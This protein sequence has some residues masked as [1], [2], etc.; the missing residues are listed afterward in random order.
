MKK[1]QSLVV[2]G[3]QLDKIETKV[4]KLL[5]KEISIKPHD[6]KPLVTF[7]DLKSSPTFK[8]KLQ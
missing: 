2:I 4:D 3:K 7:Q 6:Q 1:T 5:P 8:K